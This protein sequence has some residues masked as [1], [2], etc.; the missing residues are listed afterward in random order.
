MKKIKKGCFGY[1]K[2]QRNIEILKTIFCLALCIAIY[3]MGIYSTGSNRNLL[4][5][6]AVLGCLPMAKF[7]VNAIMFIKAKSCSSL[8]KDKLDNAGLQPVFY[9]LYFTSFKKNFQVSALDYKKKNLIMLTEDE[10]IDMQ[11]AEE[12]IKEVLKNCGYES[13]TVK[14][15]TDVDKFSERMAELK[16]LPSDEKDLTYLFDNILNVS[17]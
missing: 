7:A 2:N 12:H 3:R 9:D 13:V 6:V 5:L 10:N 11:A 8:V 17:L 4:T 14:L 15:Y 1:L 16:Q